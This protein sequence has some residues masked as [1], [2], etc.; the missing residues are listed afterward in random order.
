MFQNLVG[1]VSLMFDDALVYASGNGWSLDKLFNSIIEFIKHYG[2][3]VLM[4]VGTAALIFCIVQAFRKYVFQS[5][6]VRTGP[7]TLIVGAVFGAAFMIGGWG[8]ANDIGT[9][10]KN[11]ADGFG[12]GNVNGGNTILLYLDY[13]ANSLIHYLSNFK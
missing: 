10:L 1:A 4:M 3:Y 2:G 7:V 5:Q 12:K 13:Q 6:E 11:T 8:L 9:G